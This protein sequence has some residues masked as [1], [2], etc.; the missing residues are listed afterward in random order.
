MIFLRHTIGYMQKTQFE[1]KLR[2]YL[3]LLS[4]VPSCALHWFYLVRKVAISFY[5]IPFPSPKIKKME[6]WKNV[7]AKESFTFVDKLWFV[8]FS[9][10]FSDWQVPVGERR[11]A[12]HSW[13]KY[14][15]KSHFLKK[16]QNVSGIVVKASVTTWGGFYWFTVTTVL[17]LL[18]RLLP[19]L[20]GVL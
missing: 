7:F 2:E 1:P 9:Y 19:L 8:V 14:E 13:T 17:V 11:S 3:L 18:S 10:F 20:I 6:V 12:E 4:F 16:A 15:C 5:F